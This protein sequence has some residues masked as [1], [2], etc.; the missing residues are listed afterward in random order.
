LGTALSL[1]EKGDNSWIQHLPSVVE[2]YNGKFV[3]DSKKFRR[4]DVTKLNVNQLLAEK[5]NVKDFTP[6][7]NTSVISKFSEPMLRAIPFKH[8]IGQKV[9]LSKSAN[10]TL[11]QDAFAKNSAEGSY[12]KKVYTIE[13]VFLKTNAA[14]YF[15]MM[16]KLKG[17]EGSFYSTEVVPANFSE[18]AEQEAR[19]EDAEDRKKKKAKAKRARERK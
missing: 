4:K 16:L 10:Y 8:Q 19:N 2:S 3:R 17:L 14:Q 9:L 7:M 5:Y 11:K 13:D 6:I 1:N 18:T 15:S 12:S